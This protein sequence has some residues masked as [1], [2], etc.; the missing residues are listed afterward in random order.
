MI[1][2]TANGA[3]ALFHN[4]FKSF[5]TDS[6]G[7][8]V[9]GPESTDANVYI[10][11]D[12]GDDTA[13]RWKLTASED[14]SRFRVMNR[15]AGSW[16]T[17]IECNGQDNVELYFNA[18]KKAETVTGG[19]T[20][21]GTCTATAFAGDGSAL[22]GIAA[23]GG[24]FNTSISE[25]ANYT[26]TTSMATAFT[27]NASNSHKTIIHSCRVTNYSTSDV[28]VSGD[29]NGS[30]KFAHLIPVPAGSSV[31]LFKKPKT[32]AA[33]E[34]IRLQCSA[35]TSLSATISA[36][37]QENTDLFGSGID[38][39]N[40]NETSLAE[41][42]AAAVVES[43]LLVNDDGSNDVKATVKWTNGSNTLQS[44]LAYEMVIPAASTVE[45]LE[46]PLAMPSGHRV[47]VSANVADRL[48]ALI[49]L[50]YAS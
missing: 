8:V 4:N 17:S 46:N 32:I 25:Y 18:S 12:E 11:A 42:T 13:D 20:V 37:R 45:V 28:T 22:T 5:I 31:E 34:T 30:I 48:Q 14:A 2:A 33:S 36:E 40:T 7:I 50:K 47:R 23:G 35:A 43:I 49:A 26:V 9:Y 19:F 24:A 10:Y 44:Y 16:N 41:L 39:A 29:W 15:A 3:A 21:T 6:G 27:A 38:L 1:T